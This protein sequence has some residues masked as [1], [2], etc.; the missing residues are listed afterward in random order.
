MFVRD[1][2]FSDAGLDAY[3]AVV[4]DETVDRL[5]TLAAPLEGARVLHVNAT[6]V[7]G[8]VAEILL[9]LVPL[10][11]DAGLDV[12]WYALDAGPD[13]F[14]VTKQYHNALQGQPAP[15]SQPDFD[16][17]WDGCRR[18]AHEL[19][20]VGADYDFIV[21]HDPQPMVLRTQMPGRGKWI[22]R[23]HIDL[24]DPHREVWDM[25]APH[26]AGYDLLV[27][28]APEHVPETVEADRVE[29]GLPCIDPFRPKNRS[30]S[31]DEVRR[32]PARYGIDP[33][34]PYV[35]QVS[36]FDRWKD[37]V[38]VIETFRRVHGDRPDLQLVYMA[39]MAPDDPEGQRIYT[40]ARRVAGDDPD[41]H[42]LALDVPAERI[43]ENAYEVNAMQRG[44]AIVLQK[45]IREGFGLVVA[46]ALWKEKP[47]VAGDVG[48][49]RYQVC[50]G[51]NGYLVDSVDEAA[52][53]V[54][55][56]LEDPA[57]AAL[58]GRR[59][60]AV[61]QARFLFT[62]LL[63]QYLTWFGDL[64]TGRRPDAAAAKRSA[65]R[66]VPGVDLPGLLSS[67]REGDSPAPALD[68]PGGDAGSR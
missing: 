63:E 49:I 60:R 31:D 2:P 17:Y 44:A 35:L 65:L 39:A 56:M 46:E 34:R 1:A 7:G 45:S 28:S 3:R 21:I 11:R 58:V 38:G 66:A 54:L 30:L 32:V 6:P 8:G 16:V 47:V 13:F 12:D 24:T 59:G 42:L 61:V 15:W 41:I 57:H 5:R 67:A 19:R 43:A 33:H 10:M 52:D 68:S 18:N 4:G 48:G 55:R 62:R 14:E 23:C 37:P 53:R 27:F 20:E 25:L 22:W 26:L 40:E 64:V 51:W 29:T 36:R 50:D 9:S